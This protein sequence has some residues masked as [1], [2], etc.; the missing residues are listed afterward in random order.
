MAT[1]I[2]IT[3]LMR[4]FFGATGAV[5]MEF[6]APF[7]FYN[8]L[9]IIVAATSYFA[10]AITEEKEEQT[11][12]LLRMTNLSALAILFGKSTSRIFTGLMLLVVQVPFALLAV[13]LGGVTWEQVVITYLL[14]CSFLF[15]SANLGLFASVIARNNVRA[16]LLTGLIGWLYLW[17][18]IIV[19]WC[20]GIADFFGFRVADDLAALSENLKFLSAVNTFFEAIGINW[21]LAQWHE[22]SLA[23]C[24]FGLFFFLLAWAAFNRFATDT[25]ASEPRKKQK[26]STDAVHTRAGRASVD[27]IAWKDYH[28]I[29]GGTRVMIVKILLYA[30][31][32]IWISAAASNNRFRGGEII[33]WTIFSLSLQVALLETAIAASR[34]FRTEVRGQTLGDLYILPQNLTALIQAKRRAMMYSLGPI[35]FFLGLSLFLGIPSLLEGISHSAEAFLFII[36]FA[37]LIPLEFVFHYRLSAWFSL[38][39]KWGGLPVALA[40]SFF[41]H[42]VAIS[43]LGVAVQM[44]FGIPLIMILGALVFA[45]GS[46][47]ERMLI[48]RAA[49]N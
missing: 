24:I 35:G 14:L 31:F 27:A 36:Q 11:L 3:L 49:A 23:F 42:L 16:G 5:G 33:I 12:S 18:H 38:R 8:A 46:G 13:T 15:F 17:P 20:S 45:L 21:N 37:I 26:V 47:I 32:A 10:S 25:P 6:F 34:V 28:F 2:L 1:I 4:S 48:E 22:T 43:I 40:V 29:H 41:G 9:M 7:A 30:F 39:L 19:Y 44:V